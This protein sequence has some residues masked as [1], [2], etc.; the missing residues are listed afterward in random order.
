ML[1]H[2]DFRTSRLFAAANICLWT[3]LVLPL[4]VHPALP[5]QRCALY[6][7]AGLLVGIY[8]V[9]TLRALGQRRRAHRA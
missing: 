2:T 6:A 3:G 8:L 9:L 5:W 7:A 4:F 1:R